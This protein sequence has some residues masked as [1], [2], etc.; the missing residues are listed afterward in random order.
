[1]KKIKNIT[2]GGIQQKIFNLVLITILLIVAVYSIVFFYQSNRLT[3]LVTETNEKQQGSITAI[4]K[5]TMSS[6]VEKSLSRSTQMEAAIADDLFG[7]LEK[8]VRLIGDFAEK[9]FEAPEN[10][11]PYPVRLPDPEKAGTISVQLLTAEGIDPAEP[12][13]AEKLEL[14]GNISPLLTALYANSNISSCYIALPEGVMLLADDDPAGKYTEEGNLIT[15]PITEREWYTGAVERGD[16]YFTDVIT[17]VFT[18]QI[19]TMCAFPIYRDGELAAV[20]GADLFLDNVSAAIEALSDE[21]SFTCIINEHGHV[22]FSPRTTGIFQVKSADEASDLRNSGNEALSQLVKTALNSTTEIAMIEDEGVSYYINGAPIPTIGWAILSAV[23]KEATDRP[24]VMMEQQ[25]NTIL[26]EAQESY[27]KNISASGR[28]II[29]LLITAALLTLGGGLLLA[30]RIVAPLESMTKRIQSL[31]GEDL[32]FEMQDAYK[33]DDEIEI[34]AESFADL[35]GKTLQYVEEIKNVTAEK[36]RIG[37]ELNMATAI[38]ASQLPRLF[39]PFPNRQEIDIFA[40]MSPAREVGGDFYDFFLV[41]DDHIALVMADVSGK[42]VPAAL[43]MM[44]SRVLIKSE[45]QSG[46]SPAEALSHV[47]DQLCEGN[48][49]EFFVTVWLCVLEISTGKGLA[50]NA[51]HEHPAICRGN[52]KFDL[53]IYRHSPAVATMEGIPFRQHEFE[54]KPGDRLFVYTDGVTEATNKNNELFG[55]DRLLDALNRKPDGNPKEIL[56]NVIDDIHTFVADA[57]QFDD[58]TMMCMKYIG[59]QGGSEQKS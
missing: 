5:E 17:D 27:S 38:Q 43:F 7:S 44:V 10:Y 31:G 59:P 2:I 13:V 9:L 28:T 34:L 23:S 16:I 3:Q 45:L 56:D 51:G 32:R 52:G 19:G 53:V 8:T 58:I 48:E 18:G 26:N 57:E 39:P 50:A 46:A 15:F 49:A 22:I 37:A 33:T 6:I 40:S 14:L 20:A 30:K 21:N 54:L 55:T 12:S 47:N 41:D 36:E 29:V 42:G 1:M 11:S 4:T 25:Y 35:S 24:A